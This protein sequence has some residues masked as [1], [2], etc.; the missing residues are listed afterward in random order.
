[1]K[2]SGRWNVRLGAALAAPSPA[3]AAV[4]NP[5][6]RSNSTVDTVR[7][8]NQVAI[9]ASGLDHTPVEPGPVEPGSRV[10]G[11]QLGPVRSARAIAIVEIAVFD[12]VDALT[13]NLYRSYTGLA[14]ETRLSPPPRTTR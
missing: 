14:R 2:A 11:E 9:D 12:A 13:G 7:Y 5:P 10:L 8:W 4:V 6:R 1:M 3:M